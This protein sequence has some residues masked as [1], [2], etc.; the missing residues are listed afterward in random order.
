VI[1]ILGYARPG[2]FAALFSLLFLSLM[3]GVSLGHAFPVHADPR[4]GSTVSS[5]PAVVRIWFSGAL[6]PAFSTIVVLDANGRKVDKGDGHV[7]ASDA[8]LLEAS[9]QP[10]PSGIYRVVWNVIARD[11]HRTMGDHTFEI[12]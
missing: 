12:K 9:L 5:P 10:L 7:N 8:T 6:E 11:G 4:V 2:A 1:N 3:P